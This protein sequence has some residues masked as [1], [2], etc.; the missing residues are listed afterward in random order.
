MQSRP[1]SESLK[2]PGNKGKKS[3]YVKEPK[4]CSIEAANGFIKNLAKS[5]ES[6]SLWNTSSN[7]L[8]GSSEVMRIADGFL[9]NP[10][11]SK[12]AKN[13]D[14]RNGP[15]SPTTGSILRFF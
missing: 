7:N 9:K 8:P 5:F 14:L 2:I 3:C 12:I 15:I 11:A 4:T 13:A 10:I 6:S 1:F